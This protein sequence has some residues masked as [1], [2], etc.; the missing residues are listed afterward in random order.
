M[1]GL[2]FCGLVVAGFAFS[3]AATWPR[4]IPNAEF[5]ARGCWLIAAVLW[6]VF[7]GVSL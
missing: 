5:I 1:L 6:A 3:F 7:G 2:L 4:P